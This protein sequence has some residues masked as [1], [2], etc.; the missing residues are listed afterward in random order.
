MKISAELQPGEDVLAS[1]LATV[2]DK[3]FGA[4]GTVRGKL[5]L[6]NRRFFFSGDGRG[7]SQ[8]RAIPLQHVTSVDLHK[9]LMFA[10]VMITFA[11]GVSRCRVKYNDAA[12]FV[13]V[14]QDVVGGRVD[15]PAPSPI[16]VTSAADE[17]AKLAQLHAQG[18]LTDAEFATAKA[19]ALR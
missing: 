2:V 16:P 4:S 13:K 12:P 8:H 19:N 15:S 18:V 6:T 10:Q 1:V 9:N 11:G 3:S 14:A 7:S 17:L 5:V